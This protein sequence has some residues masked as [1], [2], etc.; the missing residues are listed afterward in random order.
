MISTHLVQLE[1]DRD[2][3]NIS[4]SGTLVKG[5]HTDFGR[6]KAREHVVM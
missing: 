4:F 3:R 6:Q 2:D 5:T 1:L